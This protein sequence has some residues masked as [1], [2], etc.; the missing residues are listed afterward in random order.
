M[1]L[2]PDMQGA[3]AADLSGREQQGDGFGQITDDIV[4]GLRRASPVWPARAAAQ[5][6]SL[7]GGHRPG[8]VCVRSGSGWPRWHPRPARAVKI[9]HHGG[10]FVIGAGWCRPSGDRDRQRPSWAIFRP[11]SVAIRSS[12]ARQDIRLDS[13]SLA[14]SG[15][16]R[17]HIHG[18]RHDALGPGG[19]GWC[20][21]RPSQSLWSESTNPR[22]T[23]RR[24]RWPRMRIQPEAK[25]AGALRKALQPG[26]VIGRGRGDDQRLFQE[27]AVCP[28]RPHERVCGQGEMPASR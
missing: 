19:R 25:A 2:N 18:S 3:V 13:L 4:A 20:C 23:A 5:V 21:T 9:I 1:V 10:H 8:A 7:A 17:G 16:A 11:R 12:G 15:P 28:P 22:S 27:R 26:R 24:R 14:A 6:I